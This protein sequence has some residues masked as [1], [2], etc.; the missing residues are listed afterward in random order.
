MLHA[1]RLPYYLW[2]EAFN[3][4]VYLQ[5]RIPNTRSGNMSPYKHWHGKK[6]TLQ[7][8][9][10]FGSETYQHVPKLFKRKLNTK[11]TEVLLVGYEGY[12]NNYRFFN[13]TTRQV[14]QSRDVTFMEESHQIDLE[15]EQAAFLPPIPT[16]DGDQA[17]DAPARPTG[18]PKGDVP[19][20]RAEPL[21]EASHQSEDGEGRTL[22]DRN[23]IKAPTPEGR[24]AAHWRKAIEEELDAHQQN[25][26]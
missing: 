9:Q 11:A 16:V 7:H 6:P 13:P 14:T 18:T 12:S 21:Q 20:Q 10:V 23:S 3:C 15:S 17:D 5:N 19:D 1:K 26:T 25:N 2:A 22:R 4:A 24:G 8:V